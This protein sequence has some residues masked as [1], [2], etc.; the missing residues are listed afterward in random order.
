MREPGGNH[1]IVELYEQ[2][3]SCE[4]FVENLEALYGAEGISVAQ[5]EAIET[6]R[7]IETAWMNARYLGLKSKTLELPSPRKAGLLVFAV[8]VS[9]FGKW[10]GIVQEQLN[11]N[12]RF[13][14]P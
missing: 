1:P 13:I 5:V 7:K 2:L 6:V 8:V 3:T 14:S 4:R 11:L 10:S 12:L 9:F